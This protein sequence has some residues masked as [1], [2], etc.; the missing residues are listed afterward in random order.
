MMFRIVNLVNLLSRI[1]N[2]MSV[3]VYNIF[4]YIYIN[5]L[6][7]KGIIWMYLPFFDN[8]NDDYDFYTI[9]IRVTHSLWVVYK[10]SY[11]II[12][13]KY[14]Y[15]VIFF[16]DYNLCIFVYFIERFICE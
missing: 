12:L 4:Y 13:D 15:A 1:Y 8:P 5:L 9:E 6:T 10:Y 11:D 7:R 16:L 2:I 3:R 14:W